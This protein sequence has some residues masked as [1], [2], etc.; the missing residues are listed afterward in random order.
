MKTLIFNGS[1]RKTGDTAF[2]L[3]RLR[4]SLSG[5]IKTV[6]AYRTKISSCV[7]CRYC[8]EHLSCAIKDDM[9]EIYN[10]II[11]ADVIIISSPL[12]FGE[13]SGPLLSL[14][15]RLQMFFSAKY[16]QKTELIKKPKIG[17][18]ILTGGGK[19]GSAKAEGTAKTL[20]S[21]M[22][23][24]ETKNV[25]SLNTDEVPSLYDMDAVVEIE[26]LAE[27]INEN[28]EN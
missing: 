2:L 25:F 3:Q 27:W 1:P 22:N 10:D 20:F 17:A 9:Q 26:K 13:L 8:K 21:L 16:F 24:K 28:A 14:F 18:L 7:D 12:Y 19:G 11:E 4:I 5:D 15:S 23:V 6:D